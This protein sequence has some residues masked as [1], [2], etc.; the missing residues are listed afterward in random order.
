[1]PAAVET[2]A[3]HVVAALPMLR[4]PAASLAVSCGYMSPV[5]AASLP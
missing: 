3:T 5:H 1:M 2:V 4:K